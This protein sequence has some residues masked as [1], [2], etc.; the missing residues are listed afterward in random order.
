MR[1][2]VI[3]LSLLSSFFSYAQN[4]PFEQVLGWKGRLSVKSIADSAK[5][6]TCVTVENNSKLKAFLFDKEMHFVKDFELEIADEDVIGG[7]IQANLIQLYLNPGGEG[8]IHNITIDTRTG[9]ARDTIFQ[10]ELKGEKL[11]GHLNAAN[12]FLYI[13]ASKKT[14]IF[15]VYRF[16]GTNMEQISFDLRVNNLDKNFTDGNLWAALSTAS[17]LSRSADIAIVDP[18]AE[19]DVDAVSSHNKLYL[20]NNKLALVMDMSGRY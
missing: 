8:L 17:G 18:E 7:F 14:P 19:A 12:S 13:T 4:K 10:L 6:S 2:L 20:L 5:K 9:D 1:F 15:H 11:M 16:G 3:A